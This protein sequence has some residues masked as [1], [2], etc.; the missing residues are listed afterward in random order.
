MSDDNDRIEIDVSPDPLSN[1]AAKKDDDIIVVDDNDT[2]SDGKPEKDPL[3]ALKKLE[4]KLKKEKEARREAENQ[5]RMASF[6]AKKASA[7][8]EDTH[9]HLVS[10]AIETVKRDNEILTANYAEAM[11]NGDYE[12]GARI[13]STINENDL[14]L[15]KLS[16]GKITIENEAR[17]R[18][19][20]APEPPKPLK[21]KER[22]DEI[23]G[24]VSK[25]SAQ[26]LKA[27]RD[28][29]NDERSINKM[30]RAHADAVEDGI[31]PDTSEYFRYIEGRLGI[32]QDENRGS[33][34]SSASKP[35]SRQ[36]PPPSAPVNRDGGS[37]N[38]AAHLTRAEAD[39]AK[40]WGMTERQYY[41]H[42]MAL[43]KE[44]R[45]N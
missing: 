12:T 39:M 30:F 8:V 15:K 4:K 6:H 7:E 45:L 26:W 36:A 18:P 25:P 3:K 33:P 42:K 11:R 38:N 10:N 41:D 22:V 27:N 35:T 1:A 20:I 28:H 16:E 21:P 13:Q 29:L 37:R 23:I 43:K 9:L 34:M 2:G 40:S 31:S 17:N 24:Q 32:N 14:N 19:P 5:A 44:G